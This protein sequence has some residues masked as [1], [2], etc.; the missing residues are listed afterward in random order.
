MPESGGHV[1]RQTPQRSQFAALWPQLS[2][3]PT[4]AARESKARR[5]PALLALAQAAARADVG[6]VRG[7]EI[8]DRPR[9]RRGYGSA[10][11]RGSDRSA[12]S[13][14][15]AVVTNGFVVVG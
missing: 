9:R 6:A 12:H 14:Q 11:A 10:A 4:R 1:H 2:R 8:F 15:M 13:R 3:T 5:G 7:L